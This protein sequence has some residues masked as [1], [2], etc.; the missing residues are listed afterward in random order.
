MPR[1]GV[2]ARV[3][4]HFKRNPI[5]VNLVYAQIHSTA[6]IVL[7]RIFVCRSPRASFTRRFSTPFSVQKSGRRNR[8]NFFRAFALPIFH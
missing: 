6:T 2:N 1:K 3:N 4:W 5:I 7:A 8:N